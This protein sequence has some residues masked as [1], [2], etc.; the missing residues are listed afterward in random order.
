MLGC[1]TVR[2]RRLT[3]N[4]CA[5]GRAHVKWRKVETESV[6]LCNVQAREA[7]L[8]PSKNN[9]IR[10]LETRQVYLSP[11]FSRGPVTELMNTGYKPVAVHSQVVEGACN[12]T[13]VQRKATTVATYPGHQDNLL[14]V[15]RCQQRRSDCY[16]ARL[17][18]EHAVTRHLHRLC[19]IEEA[20]GRLQQS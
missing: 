6:D 18:L 4:F 9:N 2:S 7:K 5:R 19:A 11:T 15:K 13:I 20:S 14:I 17:S 8:D 10:N 16:S 1:R 12:D 3:D